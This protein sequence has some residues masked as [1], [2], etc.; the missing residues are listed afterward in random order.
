MNRFWKAM[1][2]GVATG[3]VIGFYLHARS[4]RQRRK[5]MMGDPDLER[6]A[7]TMTNR[8]M[9]TADKFA[10][11]MGKEVMRAARAMQALGNR[12]S[13]GGMDRL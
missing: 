1:I 12:L 9:R 3:A 5:L 4:K 7:G 11:D 8:I 13:L 6:M 2:T 10:R